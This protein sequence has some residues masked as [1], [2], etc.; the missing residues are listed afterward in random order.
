MEDDRKNLNLQ[1]NTDGHQIGVFSA[2]GEVAGGGITTELCSATPLNRAHSPAIGGKKKGPRTARLLEGNGNS[3]SD[4]NNKGSHPL[5]GEGER[6]RIRTRP[7]KNPQK[8]KREENLQS[9]IEDCEN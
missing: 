2:L 8:S 7:R 4:A 9:K 6:L 3:K 5:Q 1:T